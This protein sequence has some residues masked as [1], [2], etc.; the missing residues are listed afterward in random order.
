TPATLTVTAQPQAKQY[1]NGDPV[2]TFLTTGLQF[3]D[4]GAS[5]LSGSLV[6]APGETVAGGP[7]VITQGSLVAN[8]NYT[9]SFTPS[10]LTIAPATL[11]ITAENKTKQYGEADPALTYLSSG[12]KFSDTAPSVL[13]GALQRAAGETVAGGPYA[14]GQGTLASNTNYTIAFTGAS[15]TITPAPL[16][17]TAE[18]K[19]KEYGAADPPLTYLSSGFKFTDSAASVL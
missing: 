14:I 16:T 13:T 12:F 7:Y 10:V 2:L 11:T 8:S 4:T 9:I 1:G 18:A 5:V 6:R 19:N 17:V 3:T 15:L